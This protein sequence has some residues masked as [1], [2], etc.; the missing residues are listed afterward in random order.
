MKILGIIA[1]YNPFHMGHAW[2]IESSKNESHCDGVMVLMSGSLTQRGDF[3]ILNKWER[4]R[5]ALSA[6]VDLVC[7]LPFGYACQSA[8]AFAH[9]GVKIFNATGV[10]DML[11]FG[12]EF[13]H[14][15]PLNSLAEILAHEPG[16]FKTFL[17]Q[18]LSTGVSFPRARELAI[19]SY[20]G[21]DVGDL[22][23]TPNNI[24]AIEYLK[25]LHKTQ[26]GINSMTVKR[27]G[28]DYHSLLPSRFLSASG[29]RSI[30][31]DA[32]ADPES[33]SAILTA[34][35]HKL[36]YSND[37]LILPFKK[38]YNPNGDDHFL[39]ALRLQILSHDVHHLKNTPYVSEGLEHKIRDSLKTATNLDEC[40]N[41]IISKRIP[42]TRVRRILCNRLLELDKVTLNHFQAQSFVPYLRVLGFNEKGRKILKMIKDQSQM[43]VLT[44]LKKSRFALTPIQNKMLYY[45]CRATDLHNQFYE[46]NYCYHRDYL[47]SPIQYPNQN[48]K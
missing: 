27:Q 38:M 1:E 33:A 26:S 25:A 4:A 36:P 46:N 43:P 44:G 35:D 8:E 7:E 41:A 48:N 3:A 32:I 40:V 19:R 10:I 37:D 28:A 9:G 16:E 29:I 31:K 15:K 23:K 22:L 12:S 6:G 30:L 47:Q 42:Q 21:D 13:G 14:I 20:L 45:D 24:L 34:L 18:G 39:N 5:L 17:K 11:S 2:Q